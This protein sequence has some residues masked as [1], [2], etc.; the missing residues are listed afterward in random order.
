M[1][2]AAMLL[3]GA[4]FTLAACGGAS[5]EDS[6]DTA[7]V[8]T[9]AVESD[10][11]PETEAAE[12]EAATDTTEAPEPQAVAART[13]PERAVMIGQDGPQF[14]AC[15]GYGQVTGLNPAGDN[16]LSVRSLPQAGSAELD[17]I[18]PD[19]GVIMCEAVN[20]F[21]GIVYR[22]EGQ[23]DLDCEAG[24]N[25]DAPEPYSGPCRS[26]WVSERFVTLIAG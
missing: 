16:Y 20:G 13:T 25:L 7:E 8:E 5:E 14:D 17:R 18:G 6:P 9:V 1:R 10:P 24:A 4:A 22:G 21:H 15:G 26:G 19:T 23:D 3:T 12:E 2:I 11:D